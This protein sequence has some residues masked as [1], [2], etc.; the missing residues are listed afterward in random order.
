[1]VLQFCRK[2]D[3]ICHVYHNAVKNG[4][5]LESYTPSGHDCHTPRVDFFLRDDHCF[6]YGKPP[7]DET[8]CLAKQ[9]ISH[10]WKDPVEEDEDEFKDKEL[11]PFFKQ[12]DT[13]PP[14][15]EWLSSWR[16]IADA[17]DFGTYKLLPRERNS[18]GKLK[19]L[20]FYSTNL[21]EDKTALEMEIDL[22]PKSASKRNTATAPIERRR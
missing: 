13:V 18:H 17:P 16:L 7:S 15:S 10:M 20:Y 14:F 4:S 3:I 8:P 2:H 6:F 22:E 11:L 5:E 1:M 21:A 19:R 9:A 12:G